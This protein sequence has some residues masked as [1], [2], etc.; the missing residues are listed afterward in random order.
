MHFPGFKGL[1][2]IRSRARLSDGTVSAKENIAHFIKD[3]FEIETPPGNVR[4]RNIIGMQGLRES[5]KGPQ[6][7]R[8]LL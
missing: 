1:R 4:L 2:G 5:M 7:S 8:G 3:L 6:R